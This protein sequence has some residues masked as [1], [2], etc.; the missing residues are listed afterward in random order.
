M[1]EYHPISTE[2]PSRLH[3]F[4]LHSFIGCELYAGGMWN[5]DIMVADVEELDNLDAS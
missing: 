4:D 1:V 3:Q 2:D 5:G